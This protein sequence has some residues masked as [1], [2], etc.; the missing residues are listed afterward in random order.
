[1][2]E[3]TRTITVPKDKEAENALDYDEARPDQLIEINLSNN[4]F[5]EFDKYEIFDS[6]NEIAD[7]F[8]GDFESD[9]ITGSEKLRQ[10]LDSDIFNRQVENDKLK[11]LKSLFEE[12]YT[13]GTGVYFYF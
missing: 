7:T 12:A 1:M 4:E 5:N 8:I 13:R 6:L 3:R 9:S 10:I 11:A 2:I